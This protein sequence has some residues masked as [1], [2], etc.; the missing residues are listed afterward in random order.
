MK[1]LLLAT[2]L[3]PF[4]IGSGAQAQTQPMRRAASCPDVLDY[5]S[6]KEAP[7]Q[8]WDF[9]SPELTIIG[10]VHT[11]DPAHEQFTRIRAAFA[12]TKP[13]LAFFEGPDRGKSET[14]EQAI[15]TMGESG[16]VRLLAR[17]AGVPARSIERTPAEQMKTLA[18]QFRLDQVLLFFAL[19]ESVRLHEREGHSGAALESA[20]A[21]LLQRVRP[22]GE[23][24]KV[25]L[26][27]SDTAGLQAAFAR[28]W[29]GRNWWQ[30]EAR[31]FSPK[32]DD[33]RTGGVF[34]G[35]I[36]RADSRNRDRH[37]V[38]LLTQAV[39]AGEKPFLVLGR[40]HV[41]MMVPALACALKNRR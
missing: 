27:F 38:Q 37:F 33:A 10:A 20:M 32:A 16:Y 18:N 21:A 13:T 29:P 4:A 11:R 12:E 7:K 39:A 28:Y 34:T 6:W 14:D 1:I 30:A 22:L 3:M 41:P 9:R 36:N 26:P 31:W 5:S 24:M 25:A 40:N 8:R 2:A 23:S 17:R 19:R 35:A 15:S